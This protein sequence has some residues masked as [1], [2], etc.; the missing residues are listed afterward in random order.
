VDI[1][2][3][4]VEIQIRYN[5]TEKGFCFVQTIFQG[6]DVLWCGVA[7]AIGGLVVGAF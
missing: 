7:A 1:E 6:F 4:V 5:D 2:L 3:R